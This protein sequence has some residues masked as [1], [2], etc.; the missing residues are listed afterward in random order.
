MVAL[1]GGTVAAAVAAFA[2]YLMFGSMIDGAGRPQRDAARR[3]QAARQADRGD[4][5]PRERRSRNSSRAWRSSRSCSARVPRSC[6]CSTRSCARCPKACTSPR[7]KQTGQAPEVRRRRAVE[8]ARVRL[9]A[10]HRWLRVAEESGARSRR[11]QDGQ[12]RDRLELHAVRRP[13]E[14]R[15]ADDAPKRAP[16]QARERGGTQ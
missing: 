4:Q 5:Q 16:R 1:G 6:T 3:D 7:V 14:Q 12:H 2:A 10:Q 15:G 11:D 8:H 13:G 9:H